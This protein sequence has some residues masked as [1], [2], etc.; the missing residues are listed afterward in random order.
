MA[1]NKSSSSHH[2]YQI[3]SPLK[4]TKFVS[5]SSESLSKLDSN[6]EVQSQKQ[7]NKSTKMKKSQTAL[8]GFETKTLQSPQSL[9][10]TTSALRRRF[11]LFRIKRSQQSNENSNIQIL[12]QTIEQ[13][14]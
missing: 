9:I 14:C 7:T 5:K 8:N 1:T 12:Q 4:S 11:S 6:T 13:F 10:N 2:Y 3:A